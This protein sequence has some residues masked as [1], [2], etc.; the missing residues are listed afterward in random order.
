MTICISFI[1]GPGIGKSTSAALAFYLLKSAG[2]NAELV[3]EY[4][5]D[6]AWDSRKMTTYDQAYFLG[7]QMRKE[8]MLYGKTDII[9]TDSP[10]AMSA[11]YARECGSHL[12]DGIISLVD[13]FYRQAYADGHR[14]YHVFLNRTK[15]YQQE[16]RYQSEDAAVKIDTDLRVI[17]GMIFKYDAVIDCETSEQGIKQLINKLFKSEI[18]NA[19]K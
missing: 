16:G 4:A 14:H 5:K 3:R 11:Y 18:E 9:V 2:L 17:V 8:S 6:W 15:P 10:I 19:Q 7:K 1:G 13:A 12:K